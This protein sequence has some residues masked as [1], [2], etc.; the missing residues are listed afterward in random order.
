MRI[1]YWSKQAE[2]YGET[3]DITFEVEYREDVPFMGEFGK[4]T[5]KCSC[6]KADMDRIEGK[7]ERKW[8][9]IETDRDSDDEIVYVGAGL[10]ALSSFS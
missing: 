7:T 10:G 1:M 4:T 6:K 9:R 2:V 5:E 3:G 8:D